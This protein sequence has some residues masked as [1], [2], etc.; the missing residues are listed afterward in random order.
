MNL[1]IPEWL[2]MVRE[3][4]E[5]LRY[6][7]VQIVV[8]DSHVTLIE[9]T[10]KTRLAAPEPVTSTDQTNWRKTQSISGPPDGQPQ[11]A[12]A[13]DKSKCMLFSAVESN[14]RRPASSRPA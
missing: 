5:T 11:A 14:P 9:R 1:E 13:G 4:V 6:G 2:Q 7:V 10:E 8:H 12:P 3:K